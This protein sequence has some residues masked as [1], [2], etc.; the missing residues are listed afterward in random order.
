[1]GVAVTDAYVLHELSTGI[2]SDDNPARVA[3]RQILD[4]FGLRPFVKRERTDAPTA[5]SSVT[6]C[7]SDQQPPPRPQGATRVANY[8]N[9]ISAWHTDGLVHL[10][11]EEAAS[12][13]QAGSD[14]AHVYVES[15]LGGSPAEER[16][17]IGLLI[18]SLFALVRR[19]EFYPL[20][21]AA[22]ARGERGLLIIGPS[23]VGK[24]TLA[25]SLV[26]AGWDYLSDDLVLLHE[27]NGG[28]NVN[29]S[30]H[31]FRRLFGLDPEAASAFPEI[32][33]V[34][35]PHLAGG[36]KWAVD[37][38]ALRPGQFTDRCIPHVILL[39]K[40]ANRPHS[41]IR[42]AGVAE[43]IR[44]AMHESPL[45]ALEP[46]R[47]PQHMNALKQLVTQTSAYRLRAGRDLKGNP[48]RA[49]ALLRPLLE[50]EPSHVP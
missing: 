49:D 8:W 21:A 31:P 22:L 20:H 11:S 44:S 13:L 34:S 19:R 26:R 27:S 36:P 16:C 15:L 39:P 23:D 9:L 24:S 2:V 14:V 25:Y 6:I 5:R 7:M 28:I 3:A 10:E 43:A 17:L 32:K 37:V 42:K 12:V 41:E 40:I 50:S 29:V 30:V 47:V 35:R 33:E 4:H 45:L 18:L 38:E 48:A 46:D 1:M